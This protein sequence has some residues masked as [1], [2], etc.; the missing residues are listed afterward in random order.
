MTRSGGGKEGLREDKK[1]QLTKEGEENSRLEIAVQRMTQS[2]EGS[3]KKMAVGQR[4]ESTEVRKATAK[5][6]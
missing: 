5:T 3:S 1:S 6:C 2:A 4:R